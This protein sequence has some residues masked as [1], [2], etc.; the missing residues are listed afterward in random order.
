MCTL[1]FRSIANDQKH[2]LNG[3]G[4][5]RIKAA[6]V[7]P[8]CHC[9]DKL[10]QWVWIRKRYNAK[11]ALSKKHLPNLVYPVESQKSVQDQ[12]SPNLVLRLAMSAGLVTVSVKYASVKLQVWQMTLHLSLAARSLRVE[13]PVPGTCHCRY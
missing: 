13:A 10:I 8:R 2:R 9:S 1:M 5:N 6:Q 11:A 4:R 12:Q 3:H 7:L